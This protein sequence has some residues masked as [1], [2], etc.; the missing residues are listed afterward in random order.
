VQKHDLVYQRIKLESQVDYISSEAQ[1]AM[2][3]DD[4]PMYKAL[5]QLHLSLMACLA[6]VAEAVDILE[7]REE[8]K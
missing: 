3:M 8:L 2:D 6:E 5:H 4:A 1:R 7:K